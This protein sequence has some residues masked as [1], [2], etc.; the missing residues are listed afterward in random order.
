MNKTGETLSIGSLTYTINPKDDFFRGVP[1][2]LNSEEAALVIAEKIFNSIP[3]GEKWVDLDFG[4]KDDKDVNGNRLSLYFNGEGPKGYRKADDI[5]WLRPE[6]YCDERAQ[7]IDDGA[8]SNDV[9]QGEI[10]DCWFIGAL[11]VLATKDE[12]L[13]GGA[14]QLKNL[15][16]DCEVDNKLAFG[17]SKGVYPPIFHFYRKKGIY[18]MRFFKEFKWRYVI[19]DDR[20]PC[21]KTNRIPVFGKCTNLHELWVPLIEKAYA[22]IHGCYETLISGFIDDALTDLTGLVAEKIKT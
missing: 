10:G 5:I 6:D 18:V 16:E 7:F 21:S 9:K 8:G 12:L 3:D 17:L 14:S 15:G 22:K 20:L 2:I 1:T 11:S 19:I 13:R 4:P